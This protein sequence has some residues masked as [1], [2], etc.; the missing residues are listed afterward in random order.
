MNMKN[1]IT[2]SLTLLW[3]LATRVYDAYCTFQ[4]TADLTHEANPLVSLFSLSW[5][6]LLIIISIL[7]MYTLYAYYL[8][9]FKHFNFFPIEKNSKSSPDVLLCNRIIVPSSITS[10]CSPGSTE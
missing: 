9:F 5:T 10:R 8:S 3:L 4:Y 6:P 2:F 1:N 7:F